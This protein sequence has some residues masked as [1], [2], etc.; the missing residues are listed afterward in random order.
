MLECSNF[1]LLGMEFST[2]LPEIPEMN[3]NKILNQASK[4]IN[5]GNIAFLPRFTK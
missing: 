5:L 4:I 2:D 1:T 3:Y